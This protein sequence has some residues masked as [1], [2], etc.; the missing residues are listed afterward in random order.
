MQKHRAIIGLLAMLGLLVTGMAVQLEPAP[1]WAAG[2]RAQLSESGCWVEIYEDD[3]YEDCWDR[4]S[5]PGNFY[6]MRN[7]PGADKG[8]WGDEVDS[9]IVGPHAKVAVYE[10]EDFS[11][12]KAVFGPNSQIP[13]L[14]RYGLGDEIDSMKIYYVR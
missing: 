6:N 9:L 13:V 14:D 10:D 4:I 3:W 1:A 2:G 11:D 7:L 12:K 8:D 5:G